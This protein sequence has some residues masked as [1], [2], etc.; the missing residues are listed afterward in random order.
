MQQVSSDV[1]K[2]IHE[3]QSLDINWDKGDK[4][5]DDIDTK[6]TES[7]GKIDKVESALKQLQKQNNADQSP[8]VSAVKE[9]VKKRL[10]QL[11]GEL[12]EKNPESLDAIDQAMADLQQE[13]DKLNNE[14]D[15]SE[16]RQQKIENALG[17][18]EVLKQA[19][20]EVQQNSGDIKEFIKDKKGQ[21]NDDLTN[22]KGV[23]DNTNNR[24]GDF[25]NEF[26]QNIEPTLRK[27]V[28]SAKQTL[29]KARGMLVEVQD[30]IPE[31]E[32]LL[33]STKKN[34][35]DGQ[36]ILK[37]TLNQYPYVHSKITEL[38]DKIR[39]I[40]KETDLN[41]IIQLLENDPAAEK[42]FFQQPVKLSE[43]KLFPIANYGTGMTPFYT[44]LAIWVG[45][46]LLISLLATDV[47]DRETAYKT[48]EVYFGRLFTFITIGLL[49]TIVV[50]LGDIFIVGVDVR[51]IGWFILF[52]VITSLIFIT[53]VYTLVSLFGDT[54]KAVA[55]IFLV[56]QIA[57]AGG[58]YPVA[59][60]PHFFQVINPFLPFTH[61]IGLMREA[62]G[63][64][65]WA[66][67]YHDLL[68]LVGTGIIFL[69]LG[70][71]LKAPL[72]KQ[73]DKMT[74]KI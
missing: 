66:R 38:A 57:G 2:F 74:K 45:A 70:G 52:G 65:V 9:N 55:I 23:A 6:I 72:N 33:G 5:S 17:Q 15:S 50:L 32:R 4:L 13:M 12:Q 22:I 54:G 40:Q 18:L 29:N 64:I 56:L 35:G 16:N 53:I 48:H 10:D 60:L 58:T 26:N 21:V 34:L 68:F 31:V 24:I 36:D 11:A 46:L 61:A 28:S 44:V 43:N 71:F 49:Q 25:V 51:E 30:T 7:I 19:L 59:L 3:V 62:V 63:G 20:Q 42:S 37:Y 8:G 67:V 73:T 47:H 1:S 14:G 39:D 41:D 69:L 27:E